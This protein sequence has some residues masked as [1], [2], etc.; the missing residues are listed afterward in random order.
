MS[1][2]AQALIAFLKCE[3]N[4]SEERAKSLRTTAA[5]IEAN[6]LSYEAERTLFL[7]VCLFANY[8]WSCFLPRASNDMVVVYM[9]YSL[10]LFY[11]PF[12]CLYCHL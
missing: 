11:P 5:S 7:F 8:A 3:A 6:A 12:L 4:S 10:H 9:M 2:A 1:V